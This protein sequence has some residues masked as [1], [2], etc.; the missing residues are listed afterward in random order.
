MTSIS[1]D[2]GAFR[3]PLVPRRPECGS[4]AMGEY[5]CPRS[6]L[7]TAFVHPSQPTGT[8]WVVIAAGLE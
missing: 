4:M 7:Y 3:T 8:L 2:C 1:S 5:I 6:F